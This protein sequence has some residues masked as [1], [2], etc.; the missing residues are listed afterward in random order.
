MKYLELIS[1]NA[2]ETAK[3]NN[4]IVA[5]EASLAIQSAIVN[6][7]REISS[8]T[9]EVARQKR[10]VP[11]NVQHTL[12]AINV[13]QLLERKMVVLTELHKELF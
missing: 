8:A 6:C 7:K 10:T 4:S 13:L 5:E 9:Q 1:Q 12:N 3:S 2:E 11:F